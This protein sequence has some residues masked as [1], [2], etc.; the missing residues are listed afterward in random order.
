LIEKRDV[1]AQTLI[2]DFY[3]GV[4]NLKWRE[5][6][7]GLSSAEIQGDNKKAA[8]R[9]VGTRLKHT[10]KGELER[11]MILIRRKWNSMLLTKRK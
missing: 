10:S 9:D 2:D 3:S 1:R 5:C 4:R 8:R 6:M 11:N 7:P